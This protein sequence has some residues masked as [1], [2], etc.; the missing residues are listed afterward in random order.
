[1]RGGSVAQRKATGS[2][3]AKAPLNAKLN[4]LS[5]CLAVFGA[6]AV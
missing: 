4:G 1:M 2:F 6:L 5:F 3:T